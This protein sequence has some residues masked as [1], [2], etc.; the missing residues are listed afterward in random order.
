MITSE[1]K[2]KKNTVKEGMKKRQISG[3]Y[4]LWFQ[5]LCPFEIPRHNNQI[6]NSPFEIW[7]IF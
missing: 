7:T 6:M 5:S 4:W 3:S 1:K 2:K